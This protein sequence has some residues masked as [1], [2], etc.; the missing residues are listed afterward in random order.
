MVS[1]MMPRPSV[2]G[3]SVTSGVSEGGERLST[4]CRGRGS[5]VR[6]YGLRDSVRVVYCDIRR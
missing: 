2:G 6:G 4:R 1:R 5:A 3:I